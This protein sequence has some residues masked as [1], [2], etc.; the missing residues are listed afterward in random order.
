MIKTG[1][2]LRMVYE[3]LQDLIA[4]DEA[5]R[6]LYESLAPDVQTALQE[7]RQNIRTY[8]E[9]KRTAEGF[10]KRTNP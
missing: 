2:D 4:R 7:Q 3:T 5:S 10:A 1:G 9:L 8:G 6:C